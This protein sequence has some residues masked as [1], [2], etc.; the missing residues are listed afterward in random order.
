MSTGVSV[1]SEGLLAVVVAAVVGVRSVA[2]V[3]QRTVGAIHRAAAP[4]LSGQWAVLAELN[5]VVVT[6]VLG[7]ASVVAIL[8][9]ISKRRF[10]SNSQC[11]RR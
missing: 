7:L 8:N 10:R 9:Q 11:S 5:Y 3:T 1:D 6:T 2:V 4:S